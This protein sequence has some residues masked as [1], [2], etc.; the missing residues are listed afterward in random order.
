MASTGERRRVIAE[1][2][3]HVVWV[4]DANGSTE[5]L[6]RRG[7]DLV[8]LTPEQ[9]SGWGWLRVVHTDAVSA[10]RV[11]SE[12]AIRDGTPY[13]SEYRG[14]TTLPRPHDGT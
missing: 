8:G 7:Q 11:A 4:T 12:G 10:A 3:P 13:R 6:N 1:W 14:R 9:T 5:Y 2:I